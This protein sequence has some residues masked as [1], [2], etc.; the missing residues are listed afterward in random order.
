MTASRRARLF[1]CWAASGIL[2]TVAAHSSESTAPDLHGPLS[3]FWPKVRH[4]WTGRLDSLNQG[5]LQTFMWVPIIWD[6]PD[7]RDLA[8]LIDRL[9]V[10]ERHNWLRTGA[11]EHRWRNIAGRKLDR[12]PF[13][14]GNSLLIGTPWDNGLVARALAATPLRVEQGSVEIGGHVIRGENLLLIAIVPNPISPSS[15]SIVFTGSSRG[16][17]LRADKVPYGESDYIVFRGIKV[18]ERGFFEWKSGVPGKDHLL[19]NQSF[20]PHLTWRVVDS[21]YARLHYDPATTPAAGL[22]RLGG[23]LDTGIDATAAFLGIPPASIRGLD[24]FLYASLDE[25][26]AQ[27][28]DPRL[29][30]IDPAMTVCTR[31]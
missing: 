7:D 28:G 19:R 21:R 23:Q 16:A 27:T 9:R 1:L 10:R 18:V 22:V 12:L 13:M 29:S 11:T 14:R 25:K 20:T 24:L 4:D 30:H 17:L 26:I 5:P 8:R 2:M 6:G 31:C 15:Y 3:D